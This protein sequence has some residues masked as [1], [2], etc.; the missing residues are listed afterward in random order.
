[1]D[2]MENEE[3]IVQQAKTDPEAFGKLYDAYYQPI[4]G[5]LYKRT[6]NAEVAKD[7]ASETFF[8]ALKN[9]RRYEQR[10]K[11][12]KAW[13][14]AI[15]VAQAGTHFRQ[16]AKTFTITTEEYPEIV[17][18][19]GYR[20]DV[21]LAEDERDRER[22]REASRLRR[23]LNQLNQRQQTIINLRFFSGQTV[24]EIAQALGMKENTIKSHIHRSVNKL[25]GLMA[26][27]DAD[28]AQN[29]YGLG[30][31]STRTIA[32]GVRG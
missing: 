21:S 1:M 30:E 28:I 32:G 31:R 25:R 19:D 16:R 11:P 2:N 14:Y 24:P 9:I 8:Q 23:L 18:E 3:L 20:P 27:E 17:A 6:G 7:L 29:A 26:K 13:L 22:K 10:G 12:F 15:A 4:F 5:F